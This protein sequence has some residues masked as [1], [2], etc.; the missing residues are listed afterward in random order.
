MQLKLKVLFVALL[1][2]GLCGLFAPWLSRPRSRPGTRPKV[3]ESCIRA[4]LAHEAKALECCA[5]YLANPT[6]LVI[7]TWG[8]MSQKHRDRWTDLACDKYSDQLWEARRKAS[9]PEI[10]ASKLLVHQNDQMR[11]LE[12]LTEHLRGA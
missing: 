8:E 9:P 1:A 12:Q 11:E 4:G 5:L 3:A 6:M 10:S 2:L 7:Q